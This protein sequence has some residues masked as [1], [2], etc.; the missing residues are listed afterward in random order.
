M[1]SY[2]NNDRKILGSHIVKPLGE[3]IYIYIYIY[4]YLFIAFYLI[5]Q[6]CIDGPMMVI[7]CRNMM[8]FLNKGI[9][10]QSVSK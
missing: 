6:Y 9:C 2:C 8:L 1:I 3:Y 10:V 7:N 4:I 5:L